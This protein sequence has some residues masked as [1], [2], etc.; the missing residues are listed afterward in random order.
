MRIEIII[1]NNNRGIKISK[2]NI[3]SFFNLR[4]DNKKSNIKYYL[5][6]SCRFIKVNIFNLNNHLFKIIKN[7]FIRI[8]IIINHNYYDKL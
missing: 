8:I 4:S 2:I 5:Y 1:Y 3:F 6:L 7:H